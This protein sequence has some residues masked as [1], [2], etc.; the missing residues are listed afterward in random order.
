MFRLKT[1]SFWRSVFLHAL[2]SK[3]SLLCLLSN[4]VIWIIDYIITILEIIRDMVQ[5]ES[6]LWKIIWKIGLWASRFSD[7]GGVIDI[8]LLGCNSVW[9]LATSPHAI[10]I[11]K[12]SIINWIR[13]EIYPPKLVERTCC[14]PIR[15]SSGPNS[16]ADP[17]LKNPWLSFLFSLRCLVKE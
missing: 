17:V 1:I 10:S 3:Y 6:C 8:G 15:K 4:T 13:D 2:R 14:T 11:E 9:N 16:D 7:G 5:Y 12:T